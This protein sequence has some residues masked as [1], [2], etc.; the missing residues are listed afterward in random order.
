[1]GLRHLHEESASEDTA[2]TMLTTR[3]QLVMNVLWFA[4]NFQSAA[5]LPIVIPVQIALW[6]TPGQIGTAPQAATLGWISTI[7]ALIALFAPPI[8]GALSDRTTGPWGRR[9]PYIAL[10]VGLL[11][12]GT[13]LLA[14]PNG[15]IALLIGLLIFQIGGNTAT[16]GYQGLLPDLVPQEQR[17]ASSGYLGVM[18]I[19][20]NA[21]SLALAAYLLGDVGASTPRD[22]IVHG[23][24]LFYALTGVVLA[25]GA[26]VTLLGVHERPLVAGSL[27]G[28][29]PRLADRVAGWLTPWRMSRFRW[30][31]LTRGSVMMGLSLFMTFIAYYFANVAHIANFVQATAVLAILALIGA[32]GSAL[33]LGLASDRIGRVP[34]VCGAT[35]CMAAAAASFVV[36]PQEAPLWAL[37]LLFGV[38]YGAYTSV[39][40]ALAVDVLPSRDAAGRDMGLWSIA[41]TAPAILA[42]LVGGLVISAADGFGDTAAGYRVVFGLAV[43]FLL[44]GAVFILRVRDQLARPPSAHTGRKRPGAGWRLAFDAGGGKARG[45]LRF[46]PVWE[47]I[48]LTLF[49]IRPIPSAPHDLLHVR[50]TTYHGKPLTLPGDVEIRRGA[51]I[52]ELHFHNR[53]LGRRAAETTPWGLLRLLREDLAAL[54][55]WSHQPDFPADTGALFGYTLLDEAAPRLGFTLRQRPHTLITWL[56]RL[57]MTGLLALYN[58]HG[59]ARLAQGATFGAYPAEVWMSI[60]ELQRRYDPADPPPSSAT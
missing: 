50:F 14:I 36:L 55:R 40:W 24:F 30:V 21:G 45:F 9:R 41:T 29:S 49:P 5:L 19:L 1:M 60:G 37:G 33:T 23:L 25:I 46:W 4:Q 35:I 8:V 22:E 18:T 28:P 34:L 42:P 16:A 48:W 3:Q 43:V 56:D 15:L 38:G 59:R 51:R 39:D 13:W 11:L 44:A 52:C 17:G 57:F 53:A 54:A 7:G 58:P 47:R 6:I 31:F 27:P 32:A 10:G 2:L 20:G 12:V 26:G